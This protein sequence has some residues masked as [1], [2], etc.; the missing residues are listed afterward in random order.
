MTTDLI[1]G[2]NQFGDSALNINVVHWWKDQD[3]RAYTAGMQ[4]MNL[5]IKKEFDQQ[6]IAFAFPS[7][8]VYLRQDN[9]WRLQ[10]PENTNPGANA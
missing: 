2:F 4:E 1:I 3:G 10:L 7:R 9:E 5:A 6:G 8:T